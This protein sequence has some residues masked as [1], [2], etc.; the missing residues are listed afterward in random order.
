MFYVFKNY[1]G[2]SKIDF[3][4]ANL[5][6]ILKNNSNNGLKAL[7]NKLISVGRD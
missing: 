4:I 1:L 3:Q 2:N 7:E 6:K 5:D